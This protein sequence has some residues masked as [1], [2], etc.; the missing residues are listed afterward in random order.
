MCAG[1]KYNPYLEEA[2]QLYLWPSNTMLKG[3]FNIHIFYK[4]RRCIVVGVII[5]ETLYTSF[6][7][8]NLNAD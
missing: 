7:D 6:L 4:V 5:G 3:T 1:E 2:G 8:L